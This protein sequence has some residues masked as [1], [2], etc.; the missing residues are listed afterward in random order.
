[1]AKLGNKTFPEVQPQNT[2]LFNSHV[3]R[4]ENL[5]SQPKSYNQILRNSNIRHNIV[6]R[7][8]FEYRRGILIFKQLC[9]ATVHCT[10]RPTRSKGVLVVF[11]KKVNRDVTF[12]CCNIFFVKI[13]AIL[14]SPQTIRTPSFCKLCKVVIRFL[15]FQNFDLF[16][17]ISSGCKQKNNRFCL[18]LV[19]IFAMT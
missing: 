8:P 9:T 19:H 14:S 6:C 12:F 15:V 2:G 17:I 3:C 18:I 11:P 10:C 4:R 7:V 13:F 5:V 16:S 1:M